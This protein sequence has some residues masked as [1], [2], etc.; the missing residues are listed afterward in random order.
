MHAFLFPSPP[1][2]SSLQVDLFG[3]WSTSISIVPI[4]YFYL[5]MSILVHRHCH[6]FGYLYRFALRLNLVVNLFVNWIVYHHHRHIIVKRSEIIWCFFRANSGDTQNRPRSHAFNAMNK[7]S[8]FWHISL[9]VLL[10]LFRLTFTKSKLINCYDGS[11]HKSVD[12]EYKINK[13]HT[14][15]DGNETL[16]QYLKI[17]VY[18]IQMMREKWILECG[19]MEERE[20]ERKRE[21]VSFSFAFSAWR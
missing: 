14:E 21:M 17:L 10:F 13:Q 5:V 6:S 12:V 11:V 16:L 15:A 19:M 8:I 9:L 18:D 3:V 7:F 1:S 20:A 2:S 4:P